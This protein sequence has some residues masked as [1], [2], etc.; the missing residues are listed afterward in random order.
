MLEFVHEDEFLIRYETENYSGGITY[1]ELIGKWFYQTKEEIDENCSYEF[2]YTEGKNLF[3]VITLYQDQEGIAGIWDME[4]CEFTHI[5]PG[6]YSLFPFVYNGSFY[7]L[8]YVHHYGVIPH[9]V[10]AKWPLNQVDFYDTE[11]Y[12]EITEY[13]LEGNMLTFNIDG[14]VATFTLDE[15]KDIEDF[16]I[17]RTAV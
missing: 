15:D 17:I 2:A 10:L 1:D 12:D 7:C 8:D 5:T 11:L 16:A 3:F 9:Y 4:K 6:S 13:T 14:A